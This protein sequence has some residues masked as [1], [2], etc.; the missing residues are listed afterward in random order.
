MVTLYYM[1]RYMHFLRDL[2]LDE[3]GSFA[4]SAEVGKWLDGTASALDRTRSATGNAGFSGSRDLEIRDILNLLE[5]ALVITDHS[6]AANRRDDGLY[7]AYNIAD[8][9]EDT[10][11]LHN[12]YS[13]LE[14]QVAVLSSGAIGADEAAD[15]LDALFASAV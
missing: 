7:H 9:G 13:M 8:F 5:D 2:L 14:G 1:R 3:P 11:R 10:L 4:V 6:I 15:V 12:L